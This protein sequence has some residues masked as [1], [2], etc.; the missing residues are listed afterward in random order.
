M[1]SLPGQKGN[2]PMSTSPSGTSYADRPAS[3]ELAGI[4]YGTKALDGKRVLVTGGTRGMGAAIAALLVTQNAHVIVTARHQG[5]ESPARLVLAD[6]TSPEGVEFVADQAIEVLGGLDVVV[7][8]VGASFAKPGGALALT[9]DDWMQALNTNLLSAVRLDRAVLPGMVEQRSGAIVH[10][11]SLQWKRPHE[12]SPAYGP[13]KAALRSYS[14]V[15]ASEFGPMGIRVNTVT[16]GY[17]ATPLAAARIAQIMDQTGI[18]QAEAEAS[19]LATIGGVPLGRPGTAAEVAR[20]VAFLVS[21]AAA[22]ITGS[23]FVI[24]GGNNRVL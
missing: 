19:L 4:Q 7:H 9:D 16:P 12:S 23:E 18:S 1:L 14:K 6:L 10:I 17:I 8:C 5:G 15:L 3:P 20:L 24:D 11:S 21:D 2:H 22:Y 13:A